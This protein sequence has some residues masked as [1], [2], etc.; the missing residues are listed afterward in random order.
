VIYSEVGYL[1]DRLVAI[2]DLPKL[3]CPWENKFAT[4]HHFLMVDPLILWRMT[5]SNLN[6]KP[7]IIPDEPNKAG[8]TIIAPNAIAVPVLRPTVKRSMINPPTA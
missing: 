7:I 6:N 8:R 1:D 3:K 4:G 2:S 5:R